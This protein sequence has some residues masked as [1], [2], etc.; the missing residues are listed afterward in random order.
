MQSGCVS[1]LMTI[2]DTLKVVERRFS[3]PD[4]HKVSDRTCTEIIRQDLIEGAHTGANQSKREAV[5]AQ[6]IAELLQNGEIRE[7]G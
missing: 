6:V 7:L 1:G 5:Q 2:F 3:R 4:W